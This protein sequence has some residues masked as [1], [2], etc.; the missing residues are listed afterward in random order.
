MEELDRFNNIVK[1]HISQCIDALLSHCLHAC[2][3]P[4][5]SLNSAILFFPAGVTTQQTNMTF[6]SIVREKRSD[7]ICMRVSACLLARRDLK[8]AIDFSNIGNPSI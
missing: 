2:G 1:K 5:W 8:S 6:K 3:E 7:T 4:A